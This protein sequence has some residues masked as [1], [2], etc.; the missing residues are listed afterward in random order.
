MKDFLTFLLDKDGRSLVKRGGTVQAVP[1]QVPTRYNPSGMDEMAIVWE[2]SLQELCSWRSWSNPFTFYYEDA[3]ILREYLYGRPISEKLYILLA[4]RGLRL[5]DTTYRWHYEF[6]YKGAI[7][8]VSLK[9]DGPGVSAQITEGGLAAK[10]KA[11]K[12]ATRELSLSDGEAILVKDDGINIAFSADMLALEGKYVAMTPNATNVKKTFTVGTI[13]TSVE[14]TTLNIGIVDVF[15]EEVNGIDYATSEKWFL[16]ATGEVTFHLQLK[17]SLNIF[18]SHTGNGGHAWLRLIKQDGSTVYEFASATFGSSGFNR[19]YTIEKTVEVTLQENDRLF[20]IAEVEIT[21]GLFNNA[22]ALVDLSLR[23]SEMKISYFARY[24]T[25]Y[26]P[27]LRLSTAYKRLVGAVTGDSSLASSTLLPQYDH[28]AL[29]SG[30]GLRSLRGAVVKTSLEEFREFTRVVLAGDI[31]VEKGRVECEAYEHFLPTDNP[32]QLGRVKNLVPTRA[33]EVFCN[34]MKVGYKVRTIDDTNGKYSAHN[35]HLYTF[36]KV[37]EVKEL[38]FI[39]PYYACPYAQEILRHNYEGKTT[40]DS[41]KDGDVFILDIEDEPELSITAHLLMATGF[42]NMG[43]LRFP[44]QE[45]MDKFTQGMRFSLGDTQLNNGLYTVGAFGD[46]GQGGFD[47]YTLEPLQAED[48]PAA[49]VRGNVY[50]LRRDPALTITGVPDPGSMY[51]MSLTPKQIARRQQ[52]WIDSVFYGFAGQSLRFE[53]TEKNRDLKA[54][55]AQGNV[56]DEDADFPIGAN[57]LFLP[58]HFDL[59][60]ETPVD[61]VQIHEEDPNRPYAFERGDGVILTGF[62]MRDGIA[63]AT[64]KEQSFKLL[65]APNNDFTMLKKYG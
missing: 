65:A 25:T 17:F 41:E 49:T 47:V 31:G 2:R 30:D 40:T 20:L 14:D 32:I 6:L 26:V 61:L 27:A 3:D 59:D 13:K 45:H 42:F 28:Y 64:Y 37:E 21:A 38:S 23:E 46:N 50:R 44:D 63:P 29:T 4:Q 52:R 5:T 15:S 58:Y 33:K 10:Y 55:D 51:N 1:D 60:A 36:D 56:V 48:A 22:I 24:K 9:H 7:D 53:T 12:G 34:T 35:T 11:G 43:I 54:V 62:S 57:P 19:S 8:T 39:S 18:K 16:Q